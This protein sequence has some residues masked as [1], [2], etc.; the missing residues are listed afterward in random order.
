M[1]IGYAGLP[2]PGGSQSP[3]TPGDMAAL[4]A[5]IDPHL[6][7]HVTDL[8]ERNTKYGDDAPLH[9]VVS[10]ADGSLWIKTSADT[11]TWATIYE[12]LPAWRP[13][14]LAG[15]YESGEFSP[16][17]RLV[18]TRAHVRGRI[19]KSDGTVFALEGV[20]VGDVPSDCRP[21]TLGSWAGGASLQGDPM[22]GVGRLEVLGVGTSSSIGGAGSLIWFSQDGTQAVG[23]AGVKW[24]DLSGSYWID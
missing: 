23:G 14:S 9:T 16:Q 10:A 24:I 8:A 6:V 1:D 20:K 13:I 15:G 18:G 17:I 7:Q 4:A 5:A 2:V 3:T 11:A 21:A 22:T 12:P 19:Q